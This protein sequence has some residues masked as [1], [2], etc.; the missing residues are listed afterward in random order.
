MFSLFKKRDKVKEKQIAKLYEQVVAQSRLPV[1]Y[2]SYK[3]PD[4]V[5]GRFELISLHVILLMLRLKAIGSEDASKISQG[6]FDE[7]FFDMDHSLREM[8]V[9]DL[10]V[11]KKIKIMISGFNGRIQAY[12]KAL[13][14]H[15]ENINDVVLRNIYGTAEEIDTEVV[16]LMGAYVTKQYD[17]IKQ[18]SMDQIVSGENIFIE[19][20]E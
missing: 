9:G 19:I 10:S 13:V 6:M 11:P 20:E 8:G 4:T 3:V 12:E 15:S 2:L 18:L 17:H 5:D 7:M 16:P 14:G 1:L